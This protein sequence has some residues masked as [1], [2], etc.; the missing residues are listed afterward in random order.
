MSANNYP[1]YSREG[2]VSTD[3]TTAMG[4]TLT[5]GSDT[6]TGTNA[7]NTLVFT[8]DAT[9]GS[10]VQRLRFKPI[11]SNTA[12]VARIFINN[13]AS[14]TVA[15]NNHLYGEQTL[16]ANDPHQAD[17]RKCRHQLGP[18]RVQC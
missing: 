17:G 18:T 2:E 7:A 14:A 8:A 16:Q 10:F 3:G 5:T 13:G 15:G 12:T 11:G 1:I 4:P 9:N 6:Y